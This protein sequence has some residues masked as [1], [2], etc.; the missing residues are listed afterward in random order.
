MKCERLN[1]VENNV[2]ATA[3]TIGRQK[4]WQLIDLCYWT[5]WWTNEQAVTSDQ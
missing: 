1:I 5:R 2:S 3:Q 4:T